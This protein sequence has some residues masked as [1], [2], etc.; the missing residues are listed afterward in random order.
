M[1][2]VLKPITP[3]MQMSKDFFKQHKRL[4]V[5]TVIVA[6]AV[7]YMY[8]D[9]LASMWNCVKANSTDHF[10]SLAQVSFGADPSSG[11]G[12]AD[13]TTTES[14][15]TL[16]AYQ[17]GVSAES[18]SNTFSPLD[19]AEAQQSLAW[20]QQQQNLPQPELLPMG[21]AP[22]YAALLNNQNFLQAGSISNGGIVSRP[23]FRNDSGSNQDFFR[24]QFIPVLDANAMAGTQLPVGEPVVRMHAQL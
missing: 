5:G 4:I 14:H 6:A 21:V 18:W 2:S 12:S 9:R 3:A 15:D 10:E 17:P 20:V 11:T 13:T 8:K 24:Q 22:E 23:N 1:E 7:A 19:Q 16:V